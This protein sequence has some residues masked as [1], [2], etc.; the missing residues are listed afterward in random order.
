M[1]I[2][3][4]GPESSGKSTLAR[5]LAIALSGTYV[6]EFAR[7]YLAERNGEYEREDLVAILR[8]QQNLERAAELSGRSP[9]VCDTGA[10][11]LYVWSQVK[12]GAAHPLIT[13]AVAK[14]DYDHIFLCAPDLP[15]APDPLREHSDPADRQAIFDRY[16]AVLEDFGLSYRVVAGEDR[17]GGVLRGVGK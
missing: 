4:T 5:R 16:V 2:L 14:M 6:P 8:G 7:E 9:L 10:L 12:Y 15:W 13:Q 1:K 11:V 3:I 17:L